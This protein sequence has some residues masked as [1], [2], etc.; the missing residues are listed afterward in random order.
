VSI[1]SVQI[2]GLTVSRMILGG[3]PF[4]GFS[5]QSAEKDREMRRYYTTARIKETL[6]Q[7][8]EL[9]INTFL[10]RAD[11]HIQ[12]LLFEYWD[13]GGAIQWFAQTCP[14]YG[15]IDNNIGEAADAGASACYLHGGWM[16]FVF[17]QDRLDEV[18]G[19]IA[20]IRDA[21]L[22]AG[23]AAHRPEV[24]AWAEEHLDVD[25]YMCSY[26]NPSPRDE[27]PE[28]N[29][30]VERYGAEDR[31]AMVA[32]IRHL[33][34]PA[35]HYKVLAAGRNDPQHAFAFVAQHLRPQ[36]AVCI[37]VYTEYNPHMLWEDLELLERSIAAA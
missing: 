6:R 22:P 13:E 8:E 26:Y 23:I 32:A 34:K 24:L 21:G 19:A 10:G 11:H 14:E 31:A 28:G 12:R 17:A 15:S 27:R 5:H 3:N 20:R 36:D 37:G 7:A 33:G 9:G 1:A 30:Q 18:P 29:R 16:D 2:G 25:F 35:I 4:S